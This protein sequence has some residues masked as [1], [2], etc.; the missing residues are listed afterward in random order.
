MVLRTLY[1]VLPTLYLQ[2]PIFMT[3]YRLSTQ[4]ISSSLAGEA[5]ILNHQKGVYYNLNEVGTF[6]W[7]MLQKS[8]ADIQQLKNAILQEFDIDE[9][10]CESDLQQLLNELI[11]E[12]LVETV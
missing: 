11:D 1:F 9:P 12:N 2:K 7:D 5:V 6:V 4:Q 10:T 8:P 3:Q